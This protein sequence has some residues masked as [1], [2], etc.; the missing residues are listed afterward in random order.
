MRQYTPPPSH[1]GGHHRS[2]RRTRSAGRY[3]TP[4]LGRAE[5]RDYKLIP[6]RKPGRLRKLWKRLAVFW[7]F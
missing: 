2:H 1:E 6:K 7:G 4:V 3:D 5:A